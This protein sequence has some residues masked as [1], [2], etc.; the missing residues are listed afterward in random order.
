MFHKS[1]N[2]DSVFRMTVSNLSQTTL[3]WKIGLQFKR[4]ARMGYLPYCM[5]QVVLLFLLCKGPCIHFVS[6]KIKK[7]DNSAGH[8]IPNVLVRP[9]GLC[10]ALAVGTIHSGPRPYQVSLLATLYSTH[11]WVIHF[12][13]TMNKSHFLTSPTKYRKNKLLDSSIVL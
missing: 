1:P 4:P 11:N 6:K 7:F 10:W 13:N 3:G 12:K 8:S 2:I 9:A 5:G